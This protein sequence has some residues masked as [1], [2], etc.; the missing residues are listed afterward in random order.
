MLKPISYSDWVNACHVII[1]IMECTFL[2]FFFI[3]SY[4]CHVL[5]NTICPVYMRFAILV[6]WVIIQNDWRDPV[7]FLWVFLRDAVYFYKII[8]LWNVLITLIDFCVAYPVCKRLI[9]QNFMELTCN[10]ICSQPHITRLKIFFTEVRHINVLLP[11]CTYDKLLIFLC[12]RHS[13]KC[14]SAE[15]YCKTSNISRTLVG[16]KIVDNS[17][18]VGASPVGAAITT[19]ELST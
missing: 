16:N 15:T 5:C 19:S 12:M 6:K 10:V 13:I 14:I 18:V 2:T 8:F 1:E 7:S 3:M 9:I 4:I 17:D 11:F